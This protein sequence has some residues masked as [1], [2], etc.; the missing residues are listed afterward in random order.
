[1]ITLTELLNILSYYPDD[2]FLIRDQ[3]TNYSEIYYTETEL[4]DSKFASMMVM[5][6]NVT[7]DNHESNSICYNITVTSS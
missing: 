6:F 5:D 4:L 3:K 1:M 7:I 2:T